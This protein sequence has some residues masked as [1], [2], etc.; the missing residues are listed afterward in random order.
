MRSA[1]KVYSTSALESW[2]SKLTSDWERYFREDDL[3]EGRRL[4]IKGAI[5]EIELGCEDAIVRMKEEGENT[6]AVVDWSGKAL[7]VRYS[8]ENERAGRA[9][10]AAGMYEIEELVCDETN[11]LPPETEEERNASFNRHN[12]SVVENS[13]HTADTSPARVLTVILDYLSASLSMQAFWITNGERKPAFGEKADPN[14]SHSERELLIQLTSYAHRAG[15]R[16]NNKLA[17]YIL[18]DISALPLFISKDYPRWCK[19]FNVIASASIESVLRGVQEVELDMNA[20]AK[21]EHE[22]RLDWHVRSSSTDFNRNEI[23][24]LLKSAE[25]PVILP[26]KGLFRISDSRARIVRDWK[27]LVDGTESGAV[28]RYMLFSLFNET[29]LTL[30][31]SDELSNWHRSFFQESP[32]DDNLPAYLREY[33]RAGVRWLKH[34]CDRGCHPL[35][36]DE[37]GLGKTL[38]VLSLLITNP[39]PDLPSLIVCPASVVPVWETEVARFFPGVITKVLTRESPFSTT[40]NNCIWIASYSQLRRQKHTLIGIEFGYCVLDEAQFIKNPEAKVTQA[41]YTLRARHRIA[42]TGT[43]M[44][45]RYEDLWALFRFLMPGLLGSQQRFSKENEKHTTAFSSHIRRQIAPFTLRRKK[46]DVL[47]ELPEKTE[48]ELLCPL[49]DFQQ[50]LYQKL[51][52]EAKQTLGDDLTRIPNEQRMHLLSLITRLRQVACD[53]SLIPNVTALPEHSGKLTVLR[54]KLEELLES[55]H[56]VVIFSQF[57]EFL[58]RVKKH[59]C[60]NLPGKVFELTGQ[61]RNRGEIVSDFQQHN[62][63]A[64]ILVSLKAG[65]TG[66]TLHSADYVFLLDPWWNPA[67]EAQAID[68]V[69]RMGQHN[70]VIVY[71]MIAQHTLEEQIQKLQIYKKGQFDE[72]IESMDDMSNF[73]LYINNL[74]KILSE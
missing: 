73:N 3:L 34:I 8:K 37:M 59:A 7:Q 35:L 18:A 51:L 71:R 21:G 29:S 2:F 44:E 39:V 74:S 56:K 49:T 32:P 22:V 61:S 67:V 11:P 27:N 64:V 20:V 16:Y 1:K 60:E 36:A 66:I 43:P 26:G 69:H 28:P 4:Y 30:K 65:G 57:V 62:G 45:N 58:K 31:L 10:A 6:Y 70:R 47:N 72:T 52:N 46:S 33:Q 14:P 41:C 40:N 55:G 17:Q 5:R 68:R 53:P 25:T 54:D 38:Q 19:H 42:M 12:L 23:K 24:R 50:K 9:L 48:L 15:F 13:L 63:P